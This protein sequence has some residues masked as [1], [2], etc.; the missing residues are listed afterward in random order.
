MGASS[1]FTSFTPA[2][3][4]DMGRALSTECSHFSEFSF[5]SKT[6]SGGEY[7]LSITVKSYAVINDQTDNKP[8]PCWKISVVWALVYPVFLKEM[9]LALLKIAVSA[10][11]FP[12]PLRQRARAP[13]WR[14]ELCVNLVTLPVCQ[15]QQGY[16]TKKKSLCQM[17]QTFQGL[18]L[19]LGPT[20]Y[21]KLA[22]L[23]LNSS[24][25]RGV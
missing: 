3:T 2:T 7:K 5:V 23:C 13:A 18:C 14:Q 24:E 1:F 20:V 8:L 22:L 15:Q 25:T 17:E 19:S 21:W 10:N 6:W 11:S 12:V 9:R 16:L 4:A